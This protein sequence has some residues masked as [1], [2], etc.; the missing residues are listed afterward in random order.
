MTPEPRFLKLAQFCPCHMWWLGGFAKHSWPTRKR[1][2]GLQ[3]TA[4]PVGAAK[5]PGRGGEVLEGTG[6]NWPKGSL[7]YLESFK[8]E[9]LESHLDSNSSSNHELLEINLQYCSSLTLSLHRVRHMVVPTFGGKTGVINLIN[10]WK[11]F[12]VRDRLRWE[13]QKRQK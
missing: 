13:D 12:S 6:K 2:R 9:P 7:F 10:A 4:R 3:D 11:T 1:T 8:A 5:S